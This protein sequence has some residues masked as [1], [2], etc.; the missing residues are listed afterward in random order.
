MGLVTY[1]EADTA[2]DIAK[3]VDGIKRV[4]KV[5]EYIE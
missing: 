2:T 3:N 5:F 1:K 4:V